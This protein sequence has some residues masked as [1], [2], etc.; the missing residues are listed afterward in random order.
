LEKNEAPDFFGSI[1]AP[2]RDAKRC[3]PEIL[4]TFDN[5]N[6]NRRNVKRQRPISVPNSWRKLLPMATSTPIYTNERDKHTDAP[7]NIR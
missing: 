1:P 5:F 2:G 6:D 3:K 7:E 4:A